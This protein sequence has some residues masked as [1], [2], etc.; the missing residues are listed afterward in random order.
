[1]NVTL[2]A[3]SG[4]DLIQQFT[5]PRIQKVI[6]N[7]E[8]V[9]QRSSLAISLI[10]IPLTVAALLANIAI[11]MALRKSTSI[12]PP[13]K[14]L[15]SNL[16][17]T[18]L[19]VGLVSQPL[20]IFHLM[21]ISRGRWHLCPYTEKFGYIPTVVLCGVTLMTVTAISVDR[22]LPL[23][24]GMRYRQIA[25]LA[26]VRILVV[27][28]WI[29]SVCTGVS[30]L[31]NIRIFFGIS[32][33][34]IASCLVI[35]TFCY[36]KIFLVLR[37]QQERVHDNGGQQPNKSSLMN[38]KKYNKS[39]LTALLIH[40]TLIACYLPYATVKAVTTFAVVTPTLLIVEVFLA[41]L[42][43]LNSTLNPVLYCWRIKEV[44]CRI[45]NTLDKLC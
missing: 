19:C 13:T 29:S 28:I 15:F 21:S 27:A 25:T 23:L 43:Y 24:M 5:C 16:A 42:V 2:E 39:V 45:K 35:S 38:E 1:M 14:L 30:F 20:F 32:C 31:W 6:Q 12:Q 26:R 44:R 37:R 22:L 40:F 34:S 18:D 41:T 36:T 7:S 10:N 9:A 11:L 4:L 33:V 8:Y 3:D 17:C